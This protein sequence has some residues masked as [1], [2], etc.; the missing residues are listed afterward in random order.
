M[1]NESDYEYEDDEYEYDDNVDDNDDVDDSSLNNSSQAQPI[2]E[3]T[4]EKSP[5]KSSEN[6]FQVPN[7]SYILRPIEEVQPVLRSLVVEVSSLL[8]V[9]EDEGQVSLIYFFS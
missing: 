2:S 1:D 8:E 9:S 5:K 6:F 7:D 4:L 3:D